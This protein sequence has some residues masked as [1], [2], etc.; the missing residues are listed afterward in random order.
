VTRLLWAG[1]VLAQPS[2]LGRVQPVP[3]IKEEGSVGPSLAQPIWVGISP[4]V[5]GHV[6]GLVHML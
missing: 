2:W 4:L 3:K 6:L 1:P 5:Y